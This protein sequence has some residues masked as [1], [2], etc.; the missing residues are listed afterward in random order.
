MSKLL[1]SRRFWTFIVAQVIAI[2]GVI[3]AHY[4]TDPFGVQMVQ[5]GIGC[6]EG[7]AGILIAAYTVDDTATGV[8]AVKAGLHPDYPPVKQ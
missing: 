4:I 6:V 3:F 2:A 7:L 8:A 5:M 1:T